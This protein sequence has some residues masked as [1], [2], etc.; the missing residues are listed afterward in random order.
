M[1]TDCTDNNLHFFFL[2]VCSQFTYNNKL[3]WFELDFLQFHSV[4][5]FAYYPS[6]QWNDF[7]TI[8]PIQCNLIMRSHSLIRV[9]EM[10]NYRCD[11]SKIGIVEVKMN[12]FVMDWISWRF[13]IGCGVCTCTASRFSVY[14][15]HTH[16]FI[17]VSKWFL[18][19]IGLNFLNWYGFYKRNF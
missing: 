10:L 16:S 3:K 18:F 13:Y 5:L 17:E 4:I 9:M 14:H 8:Y 11:E 15:T 2:R 7:H 6:F 12:W 19:L 1:S